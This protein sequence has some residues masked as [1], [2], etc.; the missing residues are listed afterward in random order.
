VAVKTPSMTHSSTIIAH[1]EGRSSE[2]LFVDDEGSASAA[3]VLLCVESLATA[4]RSAGLGPTARV[5]VVMPNN[6][7]LA[8]TALAVMSLCSFAPL[9]PRLTEDDYVTVLGDLQADAFIGID[10]F[11]HAAHRAAR[12]AGVGIIDATA[13]PTLRA[14]EPAALNRVEHPSGHALLLHTSGTT[15]RP[16]LVGLTEANLVS[17]ARSVS[18][19]LHL[20]P[21]DRC[22]NIMPLFHIHG[23][24]GVVLA[25]VVGGSS[26]ELVARFDA[27]AFRRQLQSPSISWTSAVPSVYRAALARS[28][29]THCE[30]LRL[31]RSSSA[32][33]PP[34]LWREM[35][36][37]FGCPVINAYGMTE[38]SH[39]MTSNPLPPGE[40]RLGTV[41]RSAGAEVSVLVDGVATTA[42][43][44]TGEVVVRGPGVIDRYVSASA[45]EASSHH[46]EWFR[47][48]DLGSIDAD[49]YLTLHGRIK[50]I[51][52]VAGEKVSPFEVEAAL[53]QHPAVADAAAFAAPDR[54][55]GE[56]VCV[57][58]VFRQDVDHPSQTDLHRFAADRLASFKVPRRLVVVPAI[59]LGPTGKIQR[60]R[61]AQQ[62]G[63]DD[64]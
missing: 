38:A 16:K 40:R 48:G 26:V 27:F 5:C 22:L 47:T 6:K 50:E 3:D 53:M 41:G 20:S 12:R 10:N 31:L 2:A 46:H 14:I 58:V 57:A 51:I 56:Q 62:L 54:L 15:A 29:P 42:A 18:A 35:E 30:S 11:G 28:G 34:T 63:L 59:P 43:E 36:D 44:V 39:Q 61:L 49:G 64:V 45:S 13:L 52:N 9:D 7:Q 33:L 24:V 17:S 37:R 23:L 25:S 8:I 55:R 1:L 19:T 32:A 4:L 21:A 60:T